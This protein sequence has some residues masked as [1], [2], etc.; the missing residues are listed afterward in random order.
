MKKSECWMMFIIAALIGFSRIYLMVHYPTDV[1]FA[2]V[3]GVAFGA[4][5]WYSTSFIQNFCENSNVLTNL[6]NNIDLELKT[7]HKHG[8]P[9]NSKTCATIVVLIILGFTITGFL[10][11]N[12]SYS[13]LKRCEYR[14]TDFVCMNGAEI[15][16]QDELTGEIH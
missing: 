4:F 2:A 16:S 15:E 13:D 12:S 14:G 8:R 11:M 3:E 1:I 10:K 7:R 9:L 6:N 5:V